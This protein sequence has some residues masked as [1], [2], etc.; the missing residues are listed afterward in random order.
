MH[1][2]LPL[3]FL[4]RG[5]GKPISVSIH[6]SVQFHFYFV[7]ILFTSIIS[8]LFRSRY[9]LVASD[10]SEIFG[11]NTFGNRVDFFSTAVFKAINS[12]ASFICRQP[13]AFLRLN[14]EC[15]FVSDIVIDEIGR[16]STENDSG[17]EQ[18]ID[19]IE[20]RLLLK[21]SILG[22]Q[23]QKKLL[24]ITINSVIS[25][26]SDFFRYMGWRN[27]FFVHLLN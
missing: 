12:C 27:Q 2:S 17:Q 13:Q 8:A 14:T 21:E 24:V 16:N 18:I 4:A 9:A 19:K 1:S 20:N 22:I 11:S 26:R 10:D 5:G 3:L 6:N 25:V 7:F 23:F 15:I